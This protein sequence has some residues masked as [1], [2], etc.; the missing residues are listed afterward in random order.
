MTIHFLMFYLHFLKLFYQPIK[1]TMKKP[2]RITMKSCHDA[3][4]RAEQAHMLQ[5][6]L[7]KQ[8]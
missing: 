3:L 2:N 5:L 1:V 6:N 8:A 7:F 4:A